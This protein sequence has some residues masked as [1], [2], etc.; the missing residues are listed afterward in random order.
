VVDT[1]FFERS[2]EEIVTGWTAGIPHRQLKTAGYPC[3]RLKVKNTDWLVKRTSAL[4]VTGTFTDRS[5]ARI[6]PSCGDKRIPP[7]GNFPARSVSSQSLQSTL[8]P[9]SSGNPGYGGSALLSMKYIF[10]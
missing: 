6:S 7:G 8:S 3:A 9:V 5:T 1:Y 2:Q 10:F 4:Q